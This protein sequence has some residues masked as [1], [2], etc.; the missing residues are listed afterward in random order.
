MTKVQ[1]PTLDLFIYN[2]IE[3]SDT[4][5]YE[6]YWSNLEQELIKNKFT[7][8]K[9]SS[10]Q[11]FKFA[12]PNDKIDGS[13]LRNNVQD[14]YYLNYSCSVD[15]E[16]E[17]SQITLFIN[18]QNTYLKQPDLL[19]KLNNLDAGKLSEQGYFG[20]TWMIS[21]WTVPDN[22]QISENDAF[23]IYK[24]LI[25]K[26]HQY[27]QQ[28]EL[29]GAQLYEM[30]CG[31]RQ[32]EG[33]EKNSHIIVIFY[34]DEQTFNQVGKNYYTVWRDLFL[35]RHKIIW[36]YENGRKL[37]L[38]LMQKYGNSLTN[39]A[40]ENGTDLSTKGL[41]Q[42]KNDLQTNTNNLSAYVRDIN[43]LDIQKHTVAVNLYNYDKICQDKF[44]NVK[45]LDKFSQIVKAKY[46]IQLEKDYLSLNP[47]LAILENVTATIRGM[48]EIEQA[49]QDRNLNNTIAVVGVGLATSQLSSA[50]I[51]AQNPPAKDI[52]FYKTKAF[53]SSLFA[54]AIASICV[55]AIIRLIRSL[56]R[57]K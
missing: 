26:P 23:N 6:N 56:Q 36:A 28:G 12:N 48:V 7:I 30:W 9:D 27:Y 50:I 54:G 44:S 49:Q 46:Q 8:T 57:K 40:D 53:N 45:F 51:L 21:G 3:D 24:S 35:Y 25:G 5:A 18:Q 47:D 39:T 38:R 4:T 52:P 37:K 13:F 55:W 19:P 20:Q 15:E 1:Y 43:D 32:W 11:Y 2:R 16:I 10:K 34:P 41:Q 31:D 17:L 14:A 33:I 22:S 29:L 42:L